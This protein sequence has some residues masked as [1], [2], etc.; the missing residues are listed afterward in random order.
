MSLTLREA[1]CW[2]LAVIGKKNFLKIGYV[3]VSEC[4][5]RY[6]VFGGGRELKK[7]PILQLSQALPP[8]KKKK[9][10]PKG[11]Y[12]SYVAVHEELAMTG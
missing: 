1:G 7:K 6:I 5:C 12:A 2:D 3:C 10:D 9:K 11:F 4:V 8:P